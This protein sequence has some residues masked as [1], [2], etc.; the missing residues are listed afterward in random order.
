MFKY[1]RRL[2]DG[3]DDN[4]PAVL[5]NIRKARQLWRRP[6]KLLCREGAEPAVFAKFYRVVV[7]TV[8]LYGAETWVPT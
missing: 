5:R 6:G 4:L 3:S 1:L 8:L 7:Q 2:L